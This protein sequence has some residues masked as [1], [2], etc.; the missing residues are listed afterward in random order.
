MTRRLVGKVTVLPRNYLETFCV[1]S[2]RGLL[3]FSF[4]FSCKNYFFFCLCV[5]ARVLFCLRVF[6]PLY[7]SNCLVAWIDD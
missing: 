4:L 6:V 2:G 3:P 1:D 5:C 7:F